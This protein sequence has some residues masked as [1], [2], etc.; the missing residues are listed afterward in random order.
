MEYGKDYWKEQFE[1]QMEFDASMAKFREDVDKLIRDLRSQLPP[2][3]TYLRRT[4]SR[5]RGK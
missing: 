4:A 2:P 3:R 1:E 5:S